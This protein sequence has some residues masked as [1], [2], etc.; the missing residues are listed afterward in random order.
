MARRI[1]V[2]TEFTNLPWTGSDLLWVGLADEHGNSWS[3]INAEVVIDDKVS[4][5]SRDVE[6]DGSL[7]TTLC[8]PAVL[9][10]VAPLEKTYRRPTH[11]QRRKTGGRRGYVRSAAG[12]Q[13]RRPAGGAWEAEAATEIRR[14][15][16][17]LS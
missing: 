3:A 11:L 12:R 14:R 10:S 17:E 1:F 13:G 15:R 9:A 7:I 8:P 5:F 2:D 4:D 6:P 16:L